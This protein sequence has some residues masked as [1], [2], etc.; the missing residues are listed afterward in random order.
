KTMCIYNNDGI[1]LNTSS[2]KLNNDDIKG[3]NEHLTV[4]SEMPEPDARNLIRRVN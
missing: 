3:L 4:R 1:S 2:T